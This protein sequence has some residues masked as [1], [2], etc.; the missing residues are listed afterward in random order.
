MG[1]LGDSSGVYNLYP[2]YAVRQWKR[3]EAADDTIRISVGR[4]IKDLIK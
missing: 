4:D 1:E 3:L 2:Q